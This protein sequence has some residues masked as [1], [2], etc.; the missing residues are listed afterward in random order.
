MQQSKL[1]AIV[2]SGFWYSRKYFAWGGDAF[3][4][5]LNPVLSGAEE[6]ET[7]TERERGRE[8][9]L[10]SMTAQ[11]NARVLS[12]WVVLHAWAMGQE[13]T[14]TGALEHSIRVFN[15][16]KAQRCYRARNDIYNNMIWLHARHQ[17]AEQARGLFF[18]MQEWRSAAILFSF[19]L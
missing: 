15:W 18:E 17:R 14:R 8:G 19:C 11:L 16:M 12:L 9:E 2:V 1:C 10:S 6:G 5:L 3:G 7:D 4:F 13:M